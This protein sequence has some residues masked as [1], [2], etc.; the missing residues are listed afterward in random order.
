MRLAVMLLLSLMLV[1]S[2]IANQG[3]YLVGFKERPTDMQKA[4]LKFLGASIV[5]EYK[6]FPIIEITVDPIGKM[7]IER[8]PFI[9]YIEP[10]MVYRVYAPPSRSNSEEDE[11]KWNVR[12]VYNDTQIEIWNN[13][14]MGDNPEVEL[15]ILD[16]G[17]DITH[18]EFK[19][20][21]ITCEGFGYRTCIDRNGHGTHVAGIAAAAL[22]N[23]G[24]VGVGPKIRLAIK[25]V[26]NDGGLCFISDI[27]A[28]IDDAISDGNEVISMSLGSD[29]YSASLHDAVKRAYGAGIVIVAAAGN[30]GEDVDYPGAYPEVIA[31]A[32]CDKNKQIPDWSSRGPEVEL[33][34]PGVDVYSTV[35]R[36]YDTMSGTSM[37]TP[38]VSAAAT[39][40]KAYDYTLNNTE[41]REIL[42]STAEDLGYNSTIQGNGLLRVDKAF[43]ALG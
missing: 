12:M 19:D 6:N 7:M 20:R 1:T 22:D 30:D 25:K 9:K 3:T 28:G 23:E 2:T 41:I 24:M 37:A 16:T 21:I 38:H 10:N 18:P 4:L 40:L 36:G 35:P 8:L 33:T 14:T 13:Y 11:I 29:S 39:L 31:V 26:C 17:I 34:A 27:I 15:A 5:R 42:D 43:E 32:A